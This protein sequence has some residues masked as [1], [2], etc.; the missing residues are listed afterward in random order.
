MPEKPENVKKPDKVKK[1]EEEWREQLTPEQYHVTREKGTERA[2]TGELT[3]NKAAGKYN[4]ICC[5][6]ELFTSESKFD[7][8]CGWPSFDTQASDEAVGKQI[9]TSH[10]MV[11]EEIVCTK[12]DAHLGHV[13]DDGPTPTGLRY[14]VNSASLKFEEKDG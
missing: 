8:G 2:F 14:C 1:T 13:F 11:R 10:G 3:D 9:D 12:C 7:S 6:A 5:G 4:C